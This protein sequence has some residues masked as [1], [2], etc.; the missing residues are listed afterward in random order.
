MNTDFCKNFQQ[1]FPRGVF[2]TLRAVLAWKQGGLSIM[3]SN[4]DD[5]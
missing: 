3:I 2:S 1:I 4:M 5:Y